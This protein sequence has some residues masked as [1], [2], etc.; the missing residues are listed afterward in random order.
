[1]PNPWTHIENDA[2]TYTGPR[3]EPT[4]KLPSLGQRL[5][6]IGEGYR[7]KVEARR[8]HRD[9]VDR[10]IDA[11]GRFY[12]RTFPSSEPSILGPTTLAEATELDPHHALASTE[13]LTHGNDVLVEWDEAMEGGRR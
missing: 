7:A 8:T 10:A 6:E 9:E 5:A 4:Y 12:G 3:E 13:Q 1:M 11:I 2:N